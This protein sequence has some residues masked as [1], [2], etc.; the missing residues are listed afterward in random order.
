MMRSRILLVDDNKVTCKVVEAMLKGMEYMVQVAHSGEQGL[1]RFSQEIFDLVVSDVNM[2]GIDGIEMIQQ[3]RA[4]DPTMVPII[5]TSRRDQE[6]AVRALECGVHRF[7]VKPLDREELKAKVDDAFVERQR[8]VETRLMIGDLIQLRGEMQQEIAERDQMLTR[9]ERYLQH[10]LDAAPFGI[11]STD[12]DGM[13]L[14][15][16]RG[17]EQ[18]YGYQSRE[19]MGRHISTLFADSQCGVAQKKD[20]HRHKSGE[21]FPVLMHCRDILDDAEERIAHLYVVEDI[22]ERERLEFQLVNA[23][24]LSL[25]GKMAPRI[26]HEFKTPLQLVLGHAQLAQHWVKTE[27]ME[28]ALTAI[29]QILPAAQRM[30]NL[31]QQMSNLGKP[32]ESKVEALDL[33]RELEKVMEP[34]QHLGIVKHCRIDWELEEE[35]PAIQGDPGQ[36]G[37]VLQNLIVNAAQAMENASERVLTLGLRGT[38]DGRRVEITV[39]DTGS[40]IAQEDIDDVFVP[41]FTTKGKGTGLGL[42]IVKTIVERHGGSIRIESERGKGACFFLTF[43]ALGSTDEISAH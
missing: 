42:A 33:R 36:I 23:E 28:D 39:R 15:F 29:E 1:Q 32:Q 26:A 21:R 22:R 43:P 30:G 8:V 12:R 4:V 40:G 17:A 7:L 10:L 37:Q 14:T 27:K 34:L 24:R 16:N 9:V 6:T 25:L 19:T 31:V 3:M 35:L 11:L 2:P 41:F 38:A 5:M 20:Y 13:I 18:I